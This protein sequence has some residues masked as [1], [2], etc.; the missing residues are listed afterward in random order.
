MLIKTSSP[1]F[2][3]PVSM[4]HLDAK[5]ALKDLKFDAQFKR[6]KQSEFD[7]LVKTNDEKARKRKEDIADGRDISEDVRQ[8]FSDL[9]TNNMVGW[10]G[11]QDEA[12]NPVPFSHGAVF[13]AC[14][15]YSGLM[16]AIVQAFYSSFSPT[17]AA[18]LAAKN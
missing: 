17:A 1:K 14:E 8:D 9:I 12:G 11:V 10:S 6:L 4:K 7:A 3:A 5:G 13:E 18:H 15:E 16:L 2:F